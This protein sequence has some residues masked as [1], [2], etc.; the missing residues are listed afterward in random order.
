MPLVKV[1]S[2]YYEPIADYPEVNERTPIAFKA[3]R[4]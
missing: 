3:L 1:G 2:L 4:I